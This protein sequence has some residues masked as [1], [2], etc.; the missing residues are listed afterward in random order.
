MLENKKISGV[1]MVEVLVALVVIGVGMLG[2]ASLYVTTLQAKTTAQSRMKAINFAYD[3]ADRIRANRA[4]GDSTG[5][6]YTLAS[7]A[8]LSVPATNCVETSSTA[9]TICTPAQ[10]AASD[11]YLWDKLVSD[12]VK[13]LSSVQR[14]I[15]FTVPTA[16]APGVYTINLQWTEPNTTS[17]QSYSLEVQI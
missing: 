11:L 14:S 6:S 1:G 7:N 12:S 9:A 2:I 17:T 10:M 15:S 3:I 4:A 13:G 16:T 5:S 8:T